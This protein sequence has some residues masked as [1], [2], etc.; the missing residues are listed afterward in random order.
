MKKAALVLALIL[1]ALA[2]G[3][4]ALAQTRHVTTRG[5]D[6]VAPGRG[7]LL[8]RGINLGNPSRPG[9]VAPFPCR[10]VSVTIILGTPLVTRC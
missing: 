5:R 6:F 7:R 8:L 2:G 3:P 4:A 9:A 1:P 10:G